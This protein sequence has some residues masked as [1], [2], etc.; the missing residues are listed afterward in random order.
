LTR[1]RSDVR[2]SGV[3]GLPIVAAA[4]VALLGL[5][6]LGSVLIYSAAR[7]GAQAVNEAATRGRE[8]LRIY[9][10]N[11]R[12]TSLKTGEMQRGNVTTI[13]VANT[14]GG[15]SAVDYCLMA[16]RDGSIISQTTIPS[17]QVGPGVEI[18]MKPSDLGLPIEY[19]DFWLFKG[20]ISAVYF[21]TLLGN[22]FGSAY[23]KPAMSASGAVVTGTLT[24]QGSTLTQWITTTV[25]LTQGTGEPSA[26]TTVNTATG[27]TKTGSTVTSA[28]KT[29]TAAAST[30]T[31]GGF[32][33]ALMY[34]DQDFAFG[35]SDWSLTGWTND[36][37]FSSWNLKVLVGAG[38]DWG[39]KV[40]GRFLGLGGEAPLDLTDNLA[41]GGPYPAS[42]AI[43]DDAWHSAIWAWGSLKWQGYVEDQ[44]KPCLHLQVEATK[45]IGLGPTTVAT[46]ATQASTYTTTSTTMITTTSTTYDFGSD[47]VI[48]V[49]AGPHSGTRS[50][51]PPT[52]WEATPVQIMAEARFGRMSASV[53]GVTVEA[54]NSE[55]RSAEVN[56]GSWAASWS[57][58]Y[59]GRVYPDALDP[60]IRAKVTFRLRRTTTFTTSSA[61]IITKI[62]V[63][64]VG[65]RDA[66]AS[67]DALSALPS[68]GE[69]K[70]QASSAA[71]LSVVSSSTLIPALHLM[72]QATVQS[73]LRRRGSR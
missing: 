33:Y 5:I 66:A 23:G 7:Q 1:L 68:A 39:V 16:G 54:R 25:T 41:I 17:L 27:S 30:L 36:V 37:Q 26:T 20:R 45:R 63:L 3:F 58:S 73:R 42:S 57:W 12:T 38:G 65:L 35:S 53:A 44:S 28:V 19:E 24:R 72:C 48:F 62:G 50:Y 67:A 71:S 9:V 22:V 55:S 18:Q 40:S 43:L 21:H 46:S 69:P 13:S 14:W 32:V 11:S 70:A 31:S 6:L 4:A 2:A 29:T 8:L 34:Y 47:G 61:T 51:S 59:S 49:D 10:W 52:G 15:T 56:A 64:S 60:L